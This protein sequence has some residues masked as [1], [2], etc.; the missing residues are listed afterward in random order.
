MHLL[1]QSSGIRCRLYVHGMLYSRERCAVY[2]M[3]EKERCLLGNRETMFMEP[4]TVRMPSRGTVEA[5]AR[6]R[7]A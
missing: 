1:R 7:E 6:G 2:R 3:L 4:S 5:E